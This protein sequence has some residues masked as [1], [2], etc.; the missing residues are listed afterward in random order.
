M[1]DALWRWDISEGGTRMCTIVDTHINETNLDFHANTNVLIVIDANTTQQ[2]TVS[3]NALHFTPQSS[4]LSTHDWCT[5]KSATAM[6]SGCSYE[7]DMNTMQGRV[8]FQ[9]VLS[10]AA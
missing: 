5:P 8:V 7:I 2:Y 3:S 4:L 9:D 6:C 1:A 10:N